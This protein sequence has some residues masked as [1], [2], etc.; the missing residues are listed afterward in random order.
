M[1][2][3]SATRDVGTRVRRG[4]A[5]QI[6]YLQIFQEHRVELEGLGFFYEKGFQPKYTGWAIIKLALEKP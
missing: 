4:E 3:R 5:C 6:K 1:E 2:S